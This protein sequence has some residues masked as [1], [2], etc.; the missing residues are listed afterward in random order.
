MLL[1]ERKR[2]SGVSIGAKTK[3]FKFTY[4]QSIKLARGSEN[5]T[6]LSMPR[7]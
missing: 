6:K 7:G 3:D 2:E 5:F 1:R 4:K